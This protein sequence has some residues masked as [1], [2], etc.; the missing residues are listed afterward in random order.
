MGIAQQKL[1]KHWLSTANF[2]RFFAWKHPGHPLH[3]GRPGRE[4]RRRHRAA[5]EARVRDD[6]AAGRSRLGA[7][8]AS[9]DL[10]LT[11]WTPKNLKVVELAIE[12]AA[13]GREGADRLVPDRD[14]PL[15]HRAPARAR[16]A[17]RP[18]RRG[19]GRPRADAGPAQRA[20]AIAR[21]RHGDAQVLCCGIPSIRLGHYLDTAAVR[22]R[23]RPRLQLR[24]VRP[25][26]RPRPPAHEQAARSPS[27]SPLVLGSLDEKKWEL[28]S[29][30]AQAADLALD[31][32]LVPSARSRSRSRRCSRIFSAP[33]SSQ[34]A[35]RSTRATSRTRGSIRWRLSTMFPPSRA[36]RCRPSLPLRADEQL[37]LFAA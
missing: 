8:R 4:V 21:F 29:Q 30:K 37:E 12:H 10:E 7:G 19:E 36:R 6:A 1:Y 3:R 33:A 23:R 25:V 15:D 16:S 35:T 5:A 31:G 32:Q 11:N 9:T 2:E 13:G 27:T 22:D 17:R 14:R 24:D 18:H 28:L 20:K 26:H 34:P